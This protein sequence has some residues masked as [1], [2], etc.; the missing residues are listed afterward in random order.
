LVAN[1]VVP[2]DGYLTSADLIGK[3]STLRVEC[4]KCGRSGRYKPPA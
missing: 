3:H 2:R 1:S 4:P